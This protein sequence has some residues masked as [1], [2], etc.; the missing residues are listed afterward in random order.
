MECGLE[1]LNNVKVVVGD[2]GQGAERLVLQEVMLTIVNESRFLWFTWD[3]SLGARDGDPLVSTL[4]AC[5]DLLR[6]VED[7]SRI[8]VDKLFFLLMIVSHSRP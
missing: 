5:F 2:V 6:G 3:I 4:Q 1:S 7:T 8:H